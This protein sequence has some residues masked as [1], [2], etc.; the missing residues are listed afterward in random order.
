MFVTEQISSQCTSYAASRLGVLLVYT[1]PTSLMPWIETTVFGHY[2]N[3]SYVPYLM[4]QYVVLDLYRH[5]YNVAMHLHTFYLY[6][7]YWATEYQT[8]DGVPSVKPSLVFVNT[9]YITESAQP[10]LHNRMNVGGIAL[11]KCQIR[12]MH[13][14]VICMVICEMLCH[15][16]SCLFFV[17]IF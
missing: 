8:Y 13:I 6:C 10:V 9:H 11:R 1:Q 5:L 12:A 16:Y 2:A 7:R 15:K 14:T 17:L 3:P 4:S